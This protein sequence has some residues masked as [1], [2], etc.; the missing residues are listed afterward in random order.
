VP[1][2]RRRALA[3]PLPPPADLDP[4]VR[5]SRPADLDPA[6]RP[7]RPVGLDL[8]D[9]DPAGL[10]LAGRPLRPVAQVGPPAYQAGR[11]CLGA[12][13]GCLGAGRGCLGAG[14]GCLAAGRGCLAV[15]RGCLAV[16]RGCL[17]V[18]RGCL[19]VLA[20]AVRRCFLGADRDCQAWWSAGLSERQRR[21]ADRAALVDR[22]YPAVLVGRWPLRVGLADCRVG[23]ARL[24]AAARPCCLGAGLV[25]YWADLSQRPEARLAPSYFLWVFPPAPQPLPVGRLAEPPGFLEEWAVPNYRRDWPEVRRAVPLDQWVPQ[26]FLCFPPKPPESQTDRLDPSPDCRQLAQEDG[27]PCSE[28]Q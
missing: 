2:H 20:L 28:D 3:G 18:G 24:V 1:Q 17:A 16:G 5:P 26:G 23:L 19:A 8:V 6:G 12:G 27:F 14:R 7:L 15:G 25:G 9:L 13:R 4:A 22:P 10:D 11:G 21:W